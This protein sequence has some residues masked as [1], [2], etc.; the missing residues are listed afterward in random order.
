MSILDILQTSIKELQIEKN[1]K[2]I[3]QQ[4]DNMRFQIHK[5]TRNTSSAS[6]HQ[7]RGYLISGV[8]EILQALEDSILLLNSTAKL[9]HTILYFICLLLSKV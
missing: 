5:H 9:F 7:D 3:E 6:A 4:W 1:L 8:D 2:D